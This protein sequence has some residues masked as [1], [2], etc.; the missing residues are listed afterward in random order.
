MIP[1]LFVTIVS[2]C[3]M[4]G[5]IFV[6]IQQVVEAQIILSLFV[7]FWFFFGFSPPP[8]LHLQILSDS[9]INGFGFLLS[10]CEEVTAPCLTGVIQEAR[11]DSSAFFLR[12]LITL[13]LSLNC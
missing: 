10:E 1:P 9:D 3:G 13:T 2:R 5:F 4:Y 8:P 11:A 6:K 7:V 12:C